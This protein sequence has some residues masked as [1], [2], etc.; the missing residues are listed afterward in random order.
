LA[1][2]HHPSPFLSTSV[3]PSSAFSGGRVYCMSWLVILELPLLKHE[4]IVQE[5]YAPCPAPTC[6]ILHPPKNSS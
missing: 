2:E 3:P 4:P 6:Q 1:G 5:Q